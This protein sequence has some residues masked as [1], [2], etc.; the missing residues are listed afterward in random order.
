[1]LL[2]VLTL[3]KSSAKGGFYNVY[4]QY[5]ITFRNRQHYVPNGKDGFHVLFTLSQLNKSV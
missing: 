1:M 5:F 4:Q 3:E 2:R